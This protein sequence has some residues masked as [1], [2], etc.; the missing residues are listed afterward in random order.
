MTNGATRSPIAVAFP[1]A[2]VHHATFR[3]LRRTCRTQTVCAPYILYIFSRIYRL[4]P[5]NV[6]RESGRRLQVS[7][8]SLERLRKGDRVSVVYKCL[9]FKSRKTCVLNSFRWI[10][11][12]SVG[13]GEVL[14]KGSESE[15]IN[16]K[17]CPCRGEENKGR[18][19]KGKRT[20][21]LK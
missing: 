1:C 4:L 8:A 11:H 17:K 19:E 2:R 7:V 6:G 21:R 9:T 16:G 14:R 20:C 3:H 10:D 5:Q 12:F 15:E 13:W 18:D